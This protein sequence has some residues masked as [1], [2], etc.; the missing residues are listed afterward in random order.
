MKVTIDFNVDGDV[1]KKG[2][3]RTFVRGRRAIMVPMDLKLAPWTKRVMI[4]ATKAR[5][6]RPLL[7][8]A[9][10]VRATFTMRRPHDHYLR[11]VLRDTAPELP[12]LRTGDLDKMARALLDA[13]SGVIYVDDSQVVTTIMHKRFALAGAETCSAVRVV[14]L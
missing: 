4:A 9:V 14:A 12:I 11:G 1:A 3:V 10:E 6:L 13:M 7:D 8:G 2:S 5:G